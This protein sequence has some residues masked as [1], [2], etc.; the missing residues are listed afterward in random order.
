MNSFPRYDKF[1]L[2]P[3]AVHVIFIF[4]GKF[5]TT[6]FFAW[7]EFKLQISFFAILT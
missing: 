7:Q 4:S 1:H 6:N 2:Y 3:L 5:E